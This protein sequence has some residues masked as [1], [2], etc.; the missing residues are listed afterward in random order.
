MIARTRHL[1][2]SG[3]AALGARVINDRA[4]LHTARRVISSWLPGVSQ[5]YHTIGSKMGRWVLMQMLASPPTASSLPPGI[6]VAVRT[7]VLAPAGFPLYR[8]TVC[9]AWWYYL[10]T[11][12]IKEQMP[13][14]H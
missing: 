9:A 14:W 4:E 6:T 1:V 5:A 10:Q 3:E 7:L 12:T 13:T 11:E 2:N 8:L